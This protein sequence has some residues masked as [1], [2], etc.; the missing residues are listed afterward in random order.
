MLS[1]SV[2]WRM[3][4][5]RGGLAVAAGSGMHFMALFAGRERDRFV[6]V[7]VSIAIGIFVTA[8]VWP[9][10]SITVWINLIDDTMFFVIIASMPVFLFRAV[11]QKRTGAR[12]LAVAGGILAVAVVLD[13]SLTRAWSTGSPILLPAMIVFTGAAVAGVIIRYSDEAER[14]RHLFIQARDGIAVVES[15]SVSRSRA[16]ENVCQL[17]GLSPSVKGG[18]V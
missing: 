13:I 5:R 10:P 4:V 18:L 2:E 9:D 15:K 7:F 14:F 1:D 3:R 16:Y 12:A 8:M 17:H 11:Q 6:R